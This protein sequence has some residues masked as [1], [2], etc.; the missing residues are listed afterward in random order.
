MYEMRLYINEATLLNSLVRRTSC[1][2]KM[3]QTSDVFGLISMNKEILH[4][5]YMICIFKLPL[6]P[7]LVIMKSGS[8]VYSDAVSTLMGYNH[9]NV[10]VDDL[11]HAEML[12]NVGAVML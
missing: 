1:S 3:T 2:F 8:D 5:S 4:G 7:L 11:V 9:V 12:G 10:N 6:L